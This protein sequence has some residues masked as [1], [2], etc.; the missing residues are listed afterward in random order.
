MGDLIG[1][2]DVTYSREINTDMQIGFARL[3]TDA[4][5]RND[6]WTHGDRATPARALTRAAQLLER[7]HDGVNRTL[8]HMLSGKGLGGGIAYVGVLC[9]NYGSQRHGY[10]YGL[11]ASLGA[12]FNW[13]GDQTH[14]PANVVWDI[15]VVQHE[16]GHN[17]NSPHTHDYCNIG[18]S[19]LPIDNCWTRLPG[20][21]DDRAAVVHRRRRRP[22]RAAA[23]PARS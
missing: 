8:A 5:R 2:A 6:P 10:D 9:D 18:G 17:F 14:N 22:S 13:D 12:N 23:A 21:R 11:S 1:Y 20:R 19:A 7:E 4:A 16:I 15:V 3:W